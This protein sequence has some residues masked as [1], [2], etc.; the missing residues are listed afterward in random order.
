MPGPTLQEF[1]AE[2]FRALAHPTRIRLLE[3]LRDGEMSVSELQQ[4]LGIEAASVSQQLGV[5]RGQQLVVARREGSSVFYRLRDPNVTA[6]LD[7]ARAIFSSRL[8]D[9]QAL[10]AAEP[11]DAPPAGPVPSAPEGGPHPGA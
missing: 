1:K 4:R 5:L 9:L 11:G 7:V 6:L 8:S 3:L 2:L 10:S